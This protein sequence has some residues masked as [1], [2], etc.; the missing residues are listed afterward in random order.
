MAV[1]EQIVVSQ[2][3]PGAAAL[4]ASGAG[5]IVHPTGGSATQSQFMWF[6]RSGKPLETVA[7]S[8]NGTGFHSSL[9][10][11][12]RNLA[13]IRRSGGTTDIWLLDLKR[14][15]PSRFTFDPSFDM[16]AVSSPDSRRIAFT[17]TRAGTA[18]IYVKLV[19]GPGNDELLVGTADRAEGPSDWSPDG[20]FILYDTRRSDE[21]RD[22]RAL[23][24]N[25]D[26]KPFP[27]V[28]T[29]FEESNGQFSPDSTWVAYQSN[30][31][32]RTEIYVQPFPGPGLKTPI[33]TDGGYQVR[34][35]QDGKEIFYLAPDNRLMAVPI[36]L[37]SERDTVEVMTPVP[38]FSPYLTGNPRNSVS[39]HYMVSRDGQRFLVDTLK[40][41][42]LP[43]TV[44]L[45][46]K[47]RP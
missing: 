32:G 4:S 22:I 6:D 42:T 47:P 5:P 14:G 35:R 12:S 19:D 20:R 24:L 41:V 15:V 17:S 33:S 25:G 36:R 21:P 16:A 23:A 45:N 26:R 30:E 9:S 8:G 10:P 18:D 3:E 29:T 46:W 39:R 7:G 37:D 31:S 2:A 43:I 44:I 40:E 28:E 27:V 13:I 38:L 34:W 1:A 11:D